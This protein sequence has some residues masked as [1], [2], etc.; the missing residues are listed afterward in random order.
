MSGYGSLSRGGS[1]SQGF[2]PIST[3]QDTL[4]ALASLLPCCADLSG[5]GGGAGSAL[6][7]SG[8]GDGGSGGAVPGGTSLKLNG[9]AVVLVRLLGEGA[10]SFV[11]LARDRESGREFALK[12]VRSGM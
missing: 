5:R 6:G 12:V 1:S 10:V 9:R 7:G 8:G 4:Y 3:L 11:Y 2:S